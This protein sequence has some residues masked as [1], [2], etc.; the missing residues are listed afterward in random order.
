MEC[1]ENCRRPN[2]EVQNVHQL[3]VTICFLK[4]PGETGFPPQ[5]CVPRLRDLHPIQVST[6]PCVHNLRFAS[7]R[8]LPQSLQTVEPAE[9][10]RCT[11]L[12]S[13]GASAVQ[14]NKSQCNLNNNVLFFISDQIWFCWTRSKDSKRGFFRGCEAR[15]GLKK[16]VSLVNRSIL[17]SK[18][19]THL[20]VRNLV[21]SKLRRLTT[22]RQN[23]KRGHE[24][25]R[26]G[27]RRSNIITCNIKSLCEGLAWRS[28]TGIHQFP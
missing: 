3:N 14:K 15:I 9:R 1:N 2:Q 5:T 20:S 18:E 21:W 26:I 16:C 22:T 6:P 13:L 10:A 7:R 11:N 24:F 25:S 12:G 4:F 28:E 23:K 27:S 8:E 17:Q 19:L